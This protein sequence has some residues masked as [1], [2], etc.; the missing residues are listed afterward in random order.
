MGSPVRKCG[1]QSENP[2]QAST[3]AIRSVISASGMRS[4][5]CHF[6]ISAALSTAD[7]LWRVDENAIHQA[8]AGQL[9]GARPIGELLELEIHLAP[10]QC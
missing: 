8:N 3:S 7:A 4:R 5:H 6:T 2:V 9:A 10:L 1:K